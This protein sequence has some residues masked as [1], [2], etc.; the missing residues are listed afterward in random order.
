M[1][2]ELEKKEISIIL[3]GHLEHYE[4]QF[5]EFLCGGWMLPQSKAMVTI[6]PE[7]LCQ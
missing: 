6:V 4:G 1:H 3:F 5:V 7:R 2:F